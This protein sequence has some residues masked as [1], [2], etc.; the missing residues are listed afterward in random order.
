MRA[1]RSCSHCWQALSEGMQASQSV[2]LFDS[3]RGVKQSQEEHW[4]PVVREVQ[5]MRENS[6]ASSHGR[7]SLAAGPELPDASLWA[8]YVGIPRRC[9]NVVSPCIA[10]HLRCQHHDVETGK[11]HAT[12]QHGPSDYYSGQFRAPSEPRGLVQKFVRDVPP[13]PTLV[14]RVTGGCSS[15]RPQ[16]RE[17]YTQQ[18][19]S[20]C[21]ATALSLKAASFPH[22]VRR[23]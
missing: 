15:S 12:P 5:T 9:V 11:R 23:W 22:E 7:G 8:A 20:L 14:R 3:H 13:C 19:L 6:R 2:F 1:S 16:H 10:P 4:T 17:R 21:I 18:F